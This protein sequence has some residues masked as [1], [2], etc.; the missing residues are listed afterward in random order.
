MPSAR[1]ASETPPGTSG[2]CPCPGRSTLMTRYSFA[3]HATC[4]S[5]IL[6]SA[7]MEWVSTIAGCDAEPCSVKYS[8][9]AGSSAPCRVTNVSSLVALL[10]SFR[11]NDRL[12]LPSRRFTLRPQEPPRRFRRARMGRFPIASR[13]RRTPASV[14]RPTSPRPR[15]P[16]RQ[17]HPIRTNTQSAYF[18]PIERHAG[19]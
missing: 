10:F 13:I 3:S 8:P 1:L 19:A 2:H 6:P 7:R 4:L 12:R 15:P 11:G 14:V 5:H 18:A 17:R 16:R 9:E